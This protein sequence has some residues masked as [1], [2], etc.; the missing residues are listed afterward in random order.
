MTAVSE[1]IVDVS[2]PVLVDPDTGERYL[3][4]KERLIFCV[5]TADIRALD[6]R[7]DSTPIN[8][9]RDLSSDGELLTYYLFI[10]VYDLFRGKR[11]VGTGR[12]ANPLHAAV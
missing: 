5:D 8:M 10:Q 2:I 9:D 6:D 3:G 4:D 7:Q 1:E 12:T 11:M